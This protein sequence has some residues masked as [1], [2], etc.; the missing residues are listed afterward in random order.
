VMARISKILS[1]KVLGLIEEWVEKDPEKF[2]TFEREFGGLLKMGIGAD[3]AHRDQLIEL[4]R[5]ETTKTGDSEKVSLAEMIERAEE[6]QN[7]IY[8][9]SGDNRDSVLRNPSL[10]YFRSKDIEVLLLTDPVDVFVAPTIGTYKEKSLQSVE[11]ADLDLDSLESEDQESEEKELDKTLSERLILRFKDIL[12]EQVTDVRISKRLVDS[13]ATLVVGEGGLDRQMER[14]MRMMNQD[15]ER[16]KKVLEINPAHP[17]MKNITGLLDTPDKA[18]LVK[19][20]VTQVFEGA[21]LID[22]SME[23]PTE[24]VERMNALLTRATE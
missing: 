24:F 2:A 16:S 23:K 3:P 19:D 18:D 11:K 5:F 13:A 10:E 1:G 22:G 17:L 21:Q 4:S 6:S 12:G 14:M 15:F 8:Y 7:S 9:L 20:V